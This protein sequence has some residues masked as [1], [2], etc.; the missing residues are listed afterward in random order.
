MNVPDNIEAFYGCNFGKKVDGVDLVIFPPSPYIMELGRHLS[1]TGFEDRVYELGAQNVFWKE[2]GAYTGEVSPQILA[3]CGCHYALVGH[4]ER[5]FEDAHAPVPEGADR[6]DVSLFRQ[7]FTENDEHL[8]L[9]VKALLK[10]G[11]TPVICVGERLYEREAGDKFA[12]G[13]VCRQVVAALEGLTADEVARV[14]IAYEPIWAIGTG[15]VATPEQAQ[16]VCA[17][18]RQT[19]KGIYGSEA[20]EAVRVL[21]GGSVTPDNA[22]DFANMPDIDGA[23]V[24]GAS[25]DADKL[26]RIVQAFAPQLSLF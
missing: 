19:I 7:Y 24:G 5:R 9:K 21:Y 18:I 11:I 2:S 6:Y 23:L 8:N 25:L 26:K 22:V 4:S 20:A 3:K 16:E 10:V 14:V 15:L 12:I 17:A 13:K 1:E